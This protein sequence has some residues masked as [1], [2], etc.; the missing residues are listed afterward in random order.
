MNW[1][2]IAIAAV[3]I[4]SVLLSF[5]KGIVREAIGL[6]GFVAAVF[7]AGRYYQQVGSM[8]LFIENRTIAGVVGFVLVF[9]LVSFVANLVAMMVHQTTGFFFGWPDHI[10]GAVFGLL[11]GVVLVEVALFLFGTY[12]VVGLQPAIQQSIVAGVFLR[13]LPV[14]L[15][16][17]PSEFTQALKLLT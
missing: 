17:L 12:D 8:L 13:Y 7:A 4:G 14:L 16:V 6:A 10:G 5:A 9:M 15:P 3:L 2:D 11:R 1:L